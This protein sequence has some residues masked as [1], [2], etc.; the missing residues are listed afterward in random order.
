MQSKKT[1]MPDKVLKV[2]AELVAHIHDGKS[3]PDSLQSLYDWLEVEGWDELINDL[4]EDY[5][6][7]LREVAESRFRDSE[8][9]AAEGLENIDRVTDT[10]RAAFAR[11]WVNQAATGEDGY[12]APTVHCFSLKDFKGREAF[13]GV[14]VEIH[15]Q[16]GA[17]PVWHGMFKNREDFL[18]KLRASGYCLVSELPSLDD[19]RLL[20]FWIHENMK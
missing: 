20:A 15:G 16:A 10:Q 17:V 13:L 19:S 14:T 1:Q 2:C 12:T 7:N 11:H 6:I 4:D 9:A 8:V 5:A 3:L 18:S